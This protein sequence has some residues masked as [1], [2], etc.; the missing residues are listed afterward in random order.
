MKMKD[1]LEHY[2]NDDN[3]TEEAVMNMMILTTTVDAGSD[4]D[5][6]D[7][8]SNTTVLS[9]P[10]FFGSLMIDVDSPSID[11]SDDFFLCICLLS[12]VLVIT[13]FFSF[14]IVSYLLASIGWLILGEAYSFELIVFH[15]DMQRCVLLMLSASV[16]SYTFIPLFRC[17]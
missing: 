13:F 8:L 5:D 9:Y 4:D 2:S 14:F 16:Y 15:H 12:F 11:R 6:D 1:L 7:L 10:V 17:C 3:G